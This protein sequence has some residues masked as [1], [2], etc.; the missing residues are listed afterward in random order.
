MNSL[1]RKMV[2]LCRSV[3]ESSREDPS[4]PSTPSDSASPSPVITPPSSPHASLSDPPS[5]ET[6]PTSAP[7]LSNPPAP[8]LSP[9]RKEN[10][11]N[12]ELMGSTPVGDCQLIAPAC[13][14]LR[15]MALEL[16]IPAVVLN[17]AAPP[18]PP[19]SPSPAPPPNLLS[20]P[21]DILVDLISSLSV[22]DLLAMAS[23]CRLLRALVWGHCISAATPKSF[24]VALRVEGRVTAGR[25]LGT[26]PRVPRLPRSVALDAFNSY[27]AAHIMFC[28]NEGHR[29]VARAAPAV[30]LLPRM[31]ALRELDIFPRHHASPAEA[32]KWAEAIYTAARPSHLRHLAVGGAAV[33]G[34]GAWVAR[35]PETVALKEVRLEGLQATGEMAMS[36]K[37]LLTRQGQ[38]LTSLSMAA[39]PGP[40]PHE[41]TMR[42]MG[43]LMPSGGRGLLLLTSILENVPLPRLTDLSLWGTLSVGTLLR[44]PLAWGARLTSLTLICLMKSTAP[45]RVLAR[46]ALPALEQLRILSPVLNYSADPGAAGVVAAIRGRTL[47]TYAFVPFHPLFPDGGVHGGLWASMRAFSALPAK[48][49]MGEPIHEDTVSDVSLIDFDVR[50][51]V[52]TVHMASV[53]AKNAVKVLLLL[54]NVTRAAICLQ[55]HALA[56]EDELWERGVRG[57]R[58]RLSLTTLTVSIPPY[59]QMGGEVDERGSLVDLLVALDRE[60]V[61]VHTLRLHVSYLSPGVRGAPHLV[62]DGVEL[63]PL[64]TGSLL[65]FADRVWGLAHLVVTVHGAQLNR[66]RRAA[67]ITAY[68]NE[69]AEG[70]DGAVELTFQTHSGG[71]PHIVDY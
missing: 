25:R 5:P 37:L 67:M 46:P 48:L 54:P 8:I 45:L 49:T 42:W 17:V 12:M 26:P 1:W 34:V 24:S 55:R 40:R 15:E 16:S 47:D 64:P 51:G 4:P 35:L 18:P 19:H 71:V 13:P 2:A 9:L 44:L 22:A 38:S 56:D 6:A 27:E 10:D 21:A 70:L 36:I 32:R 69:L 39:E 63:P 57:T 65:D 30:A 29:E 68:R 59:R 23:T 20:L 60:R 61:W 31:L 66:P 14:N 7:S 50:A 62:V 52:R 41:S 11:H 53:E 3:S 58:P 43:P 28:Y 33:Q